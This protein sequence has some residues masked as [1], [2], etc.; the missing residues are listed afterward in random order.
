MRAIVDTNVLIVANSRDCPQ[1]NPA[2]IM[3]C[4]RLL[5]KI[6]TEGVIVID[7][8]RLIIKEYEKNV[9]NTGQPGTGDA[10]LKWV[11]V[12]QGQLQR[13]E[14]VT[15]TPTDENQ[16]AEFPADPD[17]EKFD[18]SDRKFVAVAISH[19][20]TPP[21]HNAVDSDWKIYQLALERNGLTI[22]QLC[23]DCLKQA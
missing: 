1:A 16:F 20:E 2:C 7:D 13:C 3:H 11:L 5:R 22:E 12:N 15:I 18:P 23:P 9:S 19:P 17:L 4:V 21:I 14:P 6:Q 10:F 8:S